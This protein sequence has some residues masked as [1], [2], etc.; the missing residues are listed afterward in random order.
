MSD[1]TLAT[2][3]QVENRRGGEAVHIKYLKHLYNEVQIVD[4]DFV[5]DWPN[6]FNIMLPDDKIEDKLD[7][8]LNTVAGYLQHHGKIALQMSQSKN[9]LYI[10][11]NKE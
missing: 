9:V 5:P 8:L 1:A 11:T 7:V 4:D 3:I 10:R 6:C 2:L